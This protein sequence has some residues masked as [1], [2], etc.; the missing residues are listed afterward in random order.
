[1]DNSRLARIEAHLARLTGHGDGPP[2]WLRR[3]EEEHRLPVALAVVA[4]IALQTL[5]PHTLTFRPWWLLPGL[6]LLLLIVIVL[7]RQ[8]KLDRES[9][10]L[11]GLG[12][13]LVAAASVATAWS[14]GLLVHSLVHNR[15]GGPLDS[16][17]L[18]LLNGGAVW[19]TNVI[20]F[21]LWYWEMDRG[22][23]VARAVGRRTVPD[24]LF[25][26]MTA[27]QFAT[28]DWEP[29]FTDYFYVSFTNATAFSPTDTMPLTR[30]AKLAML[31]QSA[32]SLITVALVVARAVNIFA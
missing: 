21:A 28:E 22:G 25:P 2:A 32:I 27:P 15:A 17:Q 9:A 11:R 6:E 26:Q 5:V 18:L 8:T 24:F 23:P 3:T 12:I 13:A 31:F 7:F 29:T 4:A 20:V 14:A 19:L 16:P 30:W 1:M 10:I